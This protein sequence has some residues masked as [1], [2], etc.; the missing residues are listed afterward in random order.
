M[1][2]SRSLPSALAVVLAGARP[3]RLRGGRRRQR[4]IV[5]IGPAAAPSGAPA[6]EAPA[7]SKDDALAALVPAAVSPPTARSCSAPTRRTRPT[8]SP[9]PTART[10][11]GMDVD[12]G[13]AIAQ[14]LGLKAEFQNSAFSGIIPG[15][16]GAKYELGMSSFS[17][18]AERVQDRGHGQLLH[19]PA[20]A[21]P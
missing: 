8:S 2:R 20:P 17:I 16:D 13:N 15:I 12:L 21:W 5:R 19:R 18:N 9:T 11:I 14:K 6:A 4:R 7:A 3:R 1:G 10:I